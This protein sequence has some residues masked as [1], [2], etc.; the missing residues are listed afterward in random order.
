[1]AFEAFKSIKYYDPITNMFYYAPDMGGP[2]PWDWSVGGP[3]TESDETAITVMPRKSAEVKIMVEVYPLHQ[4]VTLYTNRPEIPKWAVTY[5]MSS[6]HLF[7]EMRRYA[8]EIA[9]KYGYAV[10]VVRPNLFSAYLQ[11]R[12]KPK[13]RIIGECQI[14][15]NPCY[16]NERISINGM[17]HLACVPKPLPPPEPDFEINMMEAL[18]GWKSWQIR[19]V[20]IAGVD[21]GMLIYSQRNI[22]AVW[23]PEKAFVASCES[24]KH[25]PKVP[26]EKDTCGIYAGGKPDETNGYGK[27]L[28]EVYGWGRYVRGESGWRSEF[29]YPKSFHLKAGQ[30][31]FIDELKKYRVPIFVQQPLRI[32]DPREDGYDGDWQ[33]ETDRDFGTDQKSD[34]SEA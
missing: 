9:D 31:E 28:G 21:H 29:A 33:T 5:P 1:M 11:V 16:D 26:A 22:E 17:R 32:Y 20:S 19:K 15:G 8:T 12:E 30:E 23:F 4:R 24:G 18:V 34:P 27:I 14:C 7:A 10:S 25:C 13:P 3:S 2:Y 6:D